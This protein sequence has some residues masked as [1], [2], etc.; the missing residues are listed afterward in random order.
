MLD[1]REYDGKI[2]KKT[3]NGKYWISEYGD[4]KNCQTGNL[5]SHDRTISETM[6]YLK[7]PEGALDCSTSMHRVVYTVFVGPIPDGLQINHIDCN[8]RNNHITNLEVCTAQENI[9]HAYANNLIDNS[10]GEDHYAAI[11]TESQVRQ[12]YGLIKLGFGNTEISNL[13]GLKFR[14]VHLLRYGLRWKHLYAE[15][16]MQVI[17][18]LNLKFPLA[19]CVYIYNKC[20]VSTTPQDALGKELGIDPSQV[21]RIRTGKSWK[22]F[23]EFFGIPENTPDWRE[24]REFLVVNDHCEA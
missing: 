5:L 4:S 17:K 20:M 21:S 12:V 1:T 22:Q 13:L 9:Q 18:S 10:K 8:K 11:L 14:H 24:N 7:A 15:E 6:R 3:P 16:G 23:R 2:W 19:K